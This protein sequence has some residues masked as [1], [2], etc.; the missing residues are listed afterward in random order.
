MVRFYHPKKLYDNQL[1]GWTNDFVQSN[2]YT[3][4]PRALSLLV[5]HIGN[6]LSRIA[7]EFEKV[8]MNLDERKNITEDDIEKY[9]ATK[10]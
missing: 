7:N 5:D 8:S 1:P 10:N 4:T 2:G 3:I 9:L 6:D